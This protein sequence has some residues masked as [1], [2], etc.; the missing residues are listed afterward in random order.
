MT[1]MSTSKNGP[2]L[3]TEE[4]C[5]RSKMLS[6]LFQKAGDSYEEHA[7]TTLAGRNRE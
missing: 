5:L 1:F 6:S 2:K 4:A 7:A 3:L